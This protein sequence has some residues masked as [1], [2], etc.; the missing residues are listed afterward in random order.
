MLVCKKKKKKNV[1][2]DQSD[3]CYIKKALKFGQNATFLTEV[4]LTLH[5]H[6]DDQQSCDGL[7]Y[8]LLKCDCFSR[9]VHESNL[10]ELLLGNY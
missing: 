7:N 2:V 10:G 5:L 8:F 9:R 6:S 1:I 3:I 4:F